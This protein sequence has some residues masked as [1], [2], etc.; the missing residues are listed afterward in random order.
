MRS[1]DVDADQTGLGGQDRGCF[2]GRPLAGRPLG[3]L[4]LGG[5]PLAGRPLGGLSG[6]NLSGA[7]LSRADLSGADLSGAYLSGANLSRADL[8]GAYLSG[9]DLSRANL[10]GA[11]LSGANLSGADLSRANLSGADLSGA[12]NYTPERTTA[13]AA[14]PYL[15]GKIQAFK[16]V[17]AKGMSPIHSKRLQYEVGK[18]VEEPNANTDPGSH[19]GAGLNVADLPWVLR[20]WSQGQR[21]FLVEHTAKDIACVPHGTDGKYRV[22]RLKV[23]KDLTDALRANGV[24][25]ALPEQ[26]AA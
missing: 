24:L 14:L 12:K 10:S 23:L 2:A 19:C 15:T 9:A 3:G 26:V 18:V 4:P 1:A 8:S 21:I 6:A 16:L 17:D 22:V 7:Y 11:Y 13:L 25:P 20:E 5:R